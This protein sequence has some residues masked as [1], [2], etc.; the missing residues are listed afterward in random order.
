MNQVY[1]YIIPLPII[2]LLV[3]LLIQGGQL[4]FYKDGGELGDGK[5]IDLVAGD[6]ITIDAVSNEDKATFTFS[7][8]PVIDF[9]ENSVFSLER[10]A[11]DLKPDGNNAGIVIDLTD[12]LDAGTNEHV[13][14]Y[15]L[16]LNYGVIQSELDAAL[17][18][19]VRDTIAGVVEEFD[20]VAIL[21]IR[22]RDQISL[23]SSAQSIP[24]STAQEL[25]VTIGDS[26]GR[27][28]GQS[29][30]VWSDST[31][32]ASAHAWVDTHEVLADIRVYRYIRVMGDGHH[33][34]VPVTDV[35][36]VTEAAAA[37]SISAGEYVVALTHLDSS[38]AP[39]NSYG[40]YP[41]Y[42]GK[43][44]DTLMVGFPNQIGTPDD[45]ATTDDESVSADPRIEIWG[46]E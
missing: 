11:I 45:P 42:L 25:T 40:V 10:N 12:V 15:S 18:V 32:I 26:R 34:D 7:T 27:A 29:D 17:D 23:E 1:A 9:Y 19:S 20:D 46:V 21:N 14:T 39:S 24:N 31:L 13:A 37:G 43:D 38:V 6:G 44:S 22:Q 5:G 30:L 35:D 2:A 8:G 33:I 3:A 41:V 28:S 16:G 36:A 4:T